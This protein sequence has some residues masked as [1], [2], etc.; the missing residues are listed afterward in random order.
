MPRDHRG[1]RGHAAARGEDAFGGVHAVNVL[2]AG[3][4][5]HQDDL[6]AIGLQFGG[7]IG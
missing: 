7:F 5:P 6:A 1:V 3:L 4:D 2:G